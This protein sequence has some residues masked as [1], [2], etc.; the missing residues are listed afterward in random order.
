MLLAGAISHTSTQYM[1]FVEILN[2]VLDL[3]I[4]YFSHFSGCWAS[5]VYS[6]HSIAKCYNLFSEVKLSVRSFGFIPVNE[7]QRKG[8]KGLFK[9]FLIFSQFDLFLFS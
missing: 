6:C 1:D 5:F 2:I 8:R 7:H 4:V 3:S 9:L